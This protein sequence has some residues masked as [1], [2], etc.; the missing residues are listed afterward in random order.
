[1]TGPA[2]RRPRIFRGWWIVATGFAGQLAAAGALAWVFGVLLQPMEDDLGWSRTLL[3]GVLTIGSLVGGVVSMR[4]GPVVDR[5]GARKLMTIS[6]IVGGCALL[7]LSL[8]QA[9]WQYYL[10]WTLF[11]VCA[12][13]FGMLGPRAAI[14]N[15]FVRR[16]AF[17]FMVFTFGSAT[18]GIL[19]APVVAQIAEA[20]S[21][22]LGWVLMAFLVW[23]I[24]PLAWFTV[25]RRPEDMG[26]LP[27]G[28]DPG[29]PGAVPEAVAE[30]AV[31]TVSEAMHTRTFWLLTAGMMLT[32]L[33]ASS[34]IVHL[35]PYTVSKGFSVAQGASVV[36]VYGLSVLPS[37]A[38][39]AFLIAKLGIRR[40]LI[41]FG[42]GYA[43][44]IAIFLI[45]SS[46]P[47]IYVA[48]AQ[49]GLAIA[50]AQQLQAQAY[51]DYFGRAI[52]GALTGY[53]AFIYTLAQAGAP[54]FAAVVY[55]L[56][57]SYVIAFG[58]FSVCCVAAGVAF[59]IA[60][61]SAGRPSAAGAE[62]P[63]PPPLH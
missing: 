35:A 33:P 17:A 42:F 39:W 41:L 62:P 31:F 23:A 60:P 54:L 28:A 15:W 52:V 38:V 27:D 24:A 43:T 29:K 61:K 32:S 2:V 5:H 1:M 25:R 7:L 16:R 51:P 18:A 8:V 26:L 44:A 46:L 45:P 14:A 10:A 13:G 3:V 49:L 34:I 6:A 11:G 56:T 20:A 40:A 48:T 47:L 9:P 58:T 36:S 63:T 21:W 22:R 12:P 30:E 50:G 59:V 53:S 37:R 4:L 55:D 19:V 57:G